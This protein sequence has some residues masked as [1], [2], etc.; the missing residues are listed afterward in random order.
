MKKYILIA[1]L[2][3]TTISSCEKDDFCVEN[4]LTPNLVVKFLNY[5]D[6]TKVKKPNSLSVWAK[7]KDSLYKKIKVD[8]IILPL[9]TLATNTIYNLAIGKDSISQLSIQYETKEEYVS[10]SCGFK[11]I[12]NNVKITNNKLTKSWIDS[13]STNTIPTI[14]NQNNAH[15]TI[16]H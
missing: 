10:R 14:N 11:I 5:S 4:P 12:F 9:N 8:S 15:L 2:I 1:F 7:E 3:I 6:T 13:L 16:Y